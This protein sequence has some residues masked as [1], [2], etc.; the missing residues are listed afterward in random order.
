M[1]STSAQPMSASGLELSVSRE[2][3]PL[4]AALVRVTVD[5]DLRDAVLTDRD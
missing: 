2:A 4:A 1:T 3:A 5:S